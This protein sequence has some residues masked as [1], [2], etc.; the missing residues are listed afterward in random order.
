VPLHPH[1]PVA[2][3]GHRLPLR[4]EHPRQLRSAHRRLHPMV[5]SFPVTFL[6]LSLVSCHLIQF[7]DIRIRS[8]I[9][10]PQ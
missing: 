5:V 2:C 4:L 9:S 6:V 1:L 7:Y 3:L 10:S 8:S